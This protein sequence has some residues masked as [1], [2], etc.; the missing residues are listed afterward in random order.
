MLRDSRGHWRNKLSNLESSGQANHMVMTETLAVDI[1]C[2]LAVEATKA[3]GK[4]QALKDDVVQD[5]KEF[6]WEEIKQNT[7][8]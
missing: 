6:H 3:S 7:D 2:S 1:K 8:G 5:T 4:A